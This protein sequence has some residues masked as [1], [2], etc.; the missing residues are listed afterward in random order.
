MPGER[1]TPPTPF[2]RN[3]QNEPTLAVDAHDPDVLV[4]GANAG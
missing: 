1:G 2:S 4:A 3:K